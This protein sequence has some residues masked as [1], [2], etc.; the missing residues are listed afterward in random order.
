MCFVW[1]S[2]GVLSYAGGHRILTDFVISLHPYCNCYHNAAAAASATWDYCTATTTLSGCRCH[3]QWS[4][5][6]L[7][8]YGSCTND[9]DSRGSWCVVDRST[10]PV[11]VRAHG[12][13][14]DRLV[15]ATI[16]GAS[17]LLSGLDFDF[18]QT[19]TLG[20]CRCRNPW[21]FGG[22][23]YHGRC[24]QGTNSSGAGSGPPG[25]SAKSAWCIV[26]P[27]CA[28]PAGY[29]SGEAFDL[30]GPE[31]GRTGVSGAACELPTSYAG[32]PMYDCLTY[33]HAQGSATALAVTEPWCF[34]NTSAGNQDACAPWTC[35]GAF[36][37]ACPTFSAGTPL[38]ALSGFAAPA[39]LDA[40]CGARAALAN[41]SWCTADAPADR[42]AL[43]DAY[44]QLKGNS[45]F[46][47]L[48]NE[49]SGHGASTAVVAL[50]RLCGGQQ[51]M[52]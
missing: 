30:C 31:G 27:G 8:L 23:T 38:T 46:G 32:V 45:Q 40:L 50:T 20:G 7:K 34:T 25:Y 48:L 35:S 44:S 28:S 36:R 18:C 49:T 22:K 6:G 5:R 3:P 24:H 51:H 37:R 42:D 47:A 12:Y 16:N 15:N 33:K 9:G 10:C 43:A 17:A 1:L 29:I 19:I 14:A 2:C 39:C 21:A 11:Q 41:V 26:E 13:G 52:I 4:L